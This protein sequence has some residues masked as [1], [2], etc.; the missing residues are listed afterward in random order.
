MVLFST[1]II[2]L[3]RHLIN[4]LIMSF[5][6]TDTKP[7]YHYRKIGTVHR[8][9][10]MNAVIIP[11]YLNTR[12]PFLPQYHISWILTPKVIE[13]GSVGFAPE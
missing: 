11:V 7:L 8:D 6:Y 5:S 9:Q 4:A 10:A 12:P 13:S 2:H 3:H 1:I